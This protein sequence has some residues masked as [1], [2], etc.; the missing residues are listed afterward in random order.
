MTGIPLRRLSGLIAAVSF[1]LVGIPDVWRRAS[2]ASS[3]SPL[4]SLSDPPLLQVAVSSNTSSASNLGSSGFSSWTSWNPTVSSTPS[5]G[6]FPL[7]PDARLL[8]ALTSPLCRLILSQLIAKYGKSQLF[9]S[10][11]YEESL[12]IIAPRKKMFFSI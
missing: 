8:A 1:L 12:L 4:S 10:K 9:N 3:S 2:K 6:R 11:G 5:S 7:R